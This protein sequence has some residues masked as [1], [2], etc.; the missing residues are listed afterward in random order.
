MASGS[1][2]SGS[3]FPRKDHGLLPPLET[4]LL[5]RRARR[6]LS[7]GRLR[8]RQTKLQIRLIRGSQRSPELF[9]HAGGS[10]GQDE[11]TLMLS[12]HG[13]QDRE[14]LQSFHRAHPVAE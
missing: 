1:F 4:S 6:D 11:R 8:S 14:V 3:P 5:E 10:A 7:Q 12:F 2:G 9:A 13:R